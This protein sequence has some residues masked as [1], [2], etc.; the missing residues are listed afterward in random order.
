MKLRFLLPPL[1]VFL[2]AFSLPAISAPTVGRYIHPLVTS[3]TISGATEPNS[4][5]EFF[6][7]DGVTPAAVY[8][9]N[10][11]VAT[12]TQPVP[13]DS[14]G[15]FEDIYLDQSIVYT[16]TLRN[17]AGAFVRS[18]DDVSSGT[19][20]D[21]INVTYTYPDANADELTLQTWMDT[22]VLSKN[23]GTV[24]DF[25]V[26]D[27]TPKI[28]EIIDSFGDLTG[29]VIWI[30]DGVG[31]NLQDLV[32]NN[33]ADLYYRANDELDSPSTD[34]QVTNER[35]WFK[36]NKNA[37]GD[38]NEWQL[39]AA[40]HPG[41]V[42]DAREDI[43]NRGAGTQ[44]GLSSVLFRKEQN[45]Q[46]QIGR[47]TD[48]QFSIAEWELRYTLDLGTDDFTINPIVDDAVVGD[49]S[50]A[51][52]TIVSIAA[53][54]M[55]ASWTSGVFESG[56]TITAGGNVSNDTLSSISKSFTTRFNRFVVGKNGAGQGANVPTA[57]LAFNFQVGG[58]FA[59]EDAAGGVF[60]AAK[61]GWRMFDDLASP[62]IGI[63]LAL[64]TSDDTL[65]FFDD[66]GVKLATLSMTTGIFTPT[67]V[68]TT[69]TAALDAVGNAINT[70]GK[71]QGR[72]LYNTDTDNP[73][74][75]TGSAAADVWVDGAGT[76]VHSPS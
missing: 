58:A 65:D 76:T 8:A 6:L 10:T 39:A 34:G 51:T 48:G 32:W 70:A 74:Y 33:N 27:N 52:G 62:T 14:A 1:L 64:N 50:E 17:S 23:W 68:E 56:E 2:S 35:I 20:I 15:R 26:T 41:L 16:V 61:A 7:S 75:A 25:G 45:N 37:S 66:Q 19:Q 63:R 46:Y 47:Q 21:P 49:T 11:G 12:V 22:F 42:L 38:V 57:N 28:Q 30:E 59:I 60:G 67:G 24:A 40:L 53:T 69:T 44:S 43:P 4:T 5:L 71:Y 31:F 29:G 55:V 36:N 18:F 13:A 9:D 3:F 54:S 73:V 72:Q